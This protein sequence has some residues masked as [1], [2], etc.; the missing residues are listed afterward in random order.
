MAEPLTSFSGVVTCTRAAGVPELT[1]C[2]RSAGPAAAPTT[3]AFSAA[4]SPELPELP[5][6]LQDAVIER[7]GSGQYR[8]R[9]AAR[10]WLISAS[11]AHLHHDV[12]VKFYTAIPPR[13]VPWRKRVFWSVV[14]ALAATS[15]GLALLRAL[16]R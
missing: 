4:A 13:A 11:A 7:V 2:G 1:L 12:G 6:R 3:L 8:I 14:L 15:A 5:E 10:A 16:R 9:S